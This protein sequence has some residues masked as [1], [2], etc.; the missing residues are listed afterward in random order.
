[1]KKINFTDA[2]ETS[3]AFVT[4]DG[5]NYDVNPAQYNGGT[6]LNASTFN[7]LQDNVEEAIEEKVTYSTEEQVVG[8]WID[9]KPIYRKIITSSL[10]NNI[11]HGISNVNEFVKMNAI[12]CNLNSGKYFVV[13]S[14]RPAYTQYEIGIFADATN[15]TLEY[16]SSLPLTMEFKIIL[17]YTKTTD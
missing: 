16:Q 12:A 1:M 11:L 15:I 13:P 17:E 4:V 14:V 10:Q 8:T 3:S 6:D 5:Q 7:E 9:G 2:I